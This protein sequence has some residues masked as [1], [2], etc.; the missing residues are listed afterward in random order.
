[1]LWCVAYN[2]I[3]NEVLENEIAYDGINNQKEPQHRVSD[4]AAMRKR[5]NRSPSDH[6]PKQNGYRHTRTQVTADLCA[7]SVA[8]EMYWCK[9]IPM[10]FRL[11]VLEVRPETSR[12]SARWTVMAAEPEVQ[13]RSMRHNV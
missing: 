3:V 11:V 10:D 12:L 7:T 2:F 1:M 4:I 6:R 8:E 13:N 9:L 5:E